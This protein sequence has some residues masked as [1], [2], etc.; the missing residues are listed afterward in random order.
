MRNGFERKRNTEVQRNRRRNRDCRPPPSEHVARVIA[1]PP[2]GQDT[3]ATNPHTRTSSDESPKVTV[4][5]KKRQQQ[6]PLINYTI[7][8]ENYPNASSLY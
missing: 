4:G 7:S 6:R 5:Q 1:W 3:S 2:L 8:W